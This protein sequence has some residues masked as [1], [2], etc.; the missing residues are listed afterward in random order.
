VKP[1][2]KRVP[3]RNLGGRPAKP[4]SE[5]ALKF[6]VTLQPRAAEA[7]EEIMR[8]DESDNRSATI[9]RLILAENAKRTVV[10]RKRAN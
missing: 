1:A 9:A 2:K 4:E 6:S 10:T 8:G 7:L 3:A 5:R